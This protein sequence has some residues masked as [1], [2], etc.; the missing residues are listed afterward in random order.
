[1]IGDM[2]ALLIKALGLRNKAHMK[3]HVADEWDQVKLDETK[4]YLSRARAKARGRQVY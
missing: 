4:R 3:F 2:E 1:M